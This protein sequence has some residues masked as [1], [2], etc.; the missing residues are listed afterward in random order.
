MKHPGIVKAG[1]LTNDIKGENVNRT[2]PKGIHEYR[3]LLEE[4]QSE[5]FFLSNFR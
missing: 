1:S 4:S 3:E 5:Q 2:Q